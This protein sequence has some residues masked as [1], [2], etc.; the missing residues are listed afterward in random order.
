MVKRG[1]KVR[2]GGCQ[3]PRDA[4]ERADLHGAASDG[5]GDAFRGVRVGGRQCP[6]DAGERAGFHV[7]VD[8]GLCGTLRVGEEP[9]SAVR[10]GGSQYPRGAGERAGLRGVAGDGLGAT[11]CIGRQGIVV[12][13]GVMRVGGGF[14]VRCG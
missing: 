13:S 7:V 6:G 8:D 2:V 14:N 1:S 4:G 5:L 11:F 9:G 12:S 3:W 10:V